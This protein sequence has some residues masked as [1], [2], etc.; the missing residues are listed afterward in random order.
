MVI[1]GATVQSAVP[2]VTVSPVRCGVLVGVMAVRVD[3]MMG[4]VMV[5][6]FR[7]LW[8]FLVIL[9]ALPLA[10]IGAFVVLAVT[11]RELD[12]SAHRPADADQ[13]RGHQGHRAARP[14]AAQDRGR[15]RRAH[16]VVQG[17]RG[18]RR[19]SRHR[20]SST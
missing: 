6:L 14:G 5:I 9:C 13:Y 15:R 18:F 8:V 4:V 10:V 1:N 19:S 20:V 16:G 2:T 17:G 7:L 11:S 12:L 3:V